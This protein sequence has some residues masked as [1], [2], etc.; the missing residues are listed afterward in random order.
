[1]LVGTRMTSLGS[2]SSTP[3]TQ[4]GKG[5]TVGSSQQ[6]LH[7]LCLKFRFSVYQQAPLRFIC[8]THTSENWRNVFLE[9]TCR[10][11]SCPRKQT[12]PRPVAVP[13]AGSKLTLL[14]SDMLHIPSSRGQNPSFIL[15]VQHDY[16]CLAA[17]QS[18]YINTSQH[19]SASGGDGDEPWREK[20]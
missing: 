12:H 8:H 7:C 14:N 4:H 2:L 9:K 11:I 20:L 16:V 10:S 13:Q 18:T 5:T 15:T 6:V 19:P 1:M 3:V 17:V